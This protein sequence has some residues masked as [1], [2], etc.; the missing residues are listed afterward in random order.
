MNAKCGKQPPKGSNSWWMSDDQWEADLCHCI[1]DK[2]HEGEHNCD[3][4]SPWT[5]EWKKL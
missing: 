5:G 1:L 3:H 2:G 4:D